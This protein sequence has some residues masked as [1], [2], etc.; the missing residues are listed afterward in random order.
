MEAIK[1]G[2]AVLRRQFSQ[3]IPTRQSHKPVGTEEMGVL[4]LPEDGSF[5]NH[6]GD[7]IRIHV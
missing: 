1:P 4:W 6:G 5:C 2:Q 3:E 7:H